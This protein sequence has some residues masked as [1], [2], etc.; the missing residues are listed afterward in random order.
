MTVADGLVVLGH[1][2]LVDVDVGDPLGG[3]AEEAH[4]VVVGVALQ[5]A[6]GEVDGG[7]DAVVGVGLEH[8]VQLVGAAV[9]VEEEV[10]DADGHVVAEP[11]LH[12]GR[13]VLEDGHDRDIE[14]A[15]LHQRRADLA[16]LG[17][18]PA[19]ARR[20]ACSTPCRAP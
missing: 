7:H 13:L 11:L 20:R 17:P 12:V 8:L 2:E 16:L 10:V 3:V 18:T 15:P 1:Q 19:S 6:H 9:V 14:A 5:A 4:D